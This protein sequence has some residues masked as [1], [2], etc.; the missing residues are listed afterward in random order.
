MNR[1]FLDTNIVLDILIEERKNHLKSKEL[2][3]YLLLNNYEI[4]ISEDMLSTIYYIAKNKST[5]LK[6]FQTIQ[7]EWMIV[8]Y[9]K[10]VVTKALVFALDNNSDL[11]DT[12]QCF[13]ASSYHCECVISSDKKFVDCGVKIVNYENFLK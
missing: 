10:E 4:V 13:C 12:L 7:E 9:G 2:L 6:F 1:V 3:T 11:E 8:P 5:T